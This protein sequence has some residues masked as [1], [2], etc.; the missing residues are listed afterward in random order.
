MNDFEQYMQL[1]EI[2]PV[3]LSIEA[4]VCYGTVYH[5]KKGVPILSENAEKIK[6]AVLSMTGV[7]YVGSFVLM[8]ENDQPFSTVCV[9][10]LPRRDP[11]YLKQTLQDIKRTTEITTKAIA[12]KAQLPVADVFAVEIGGCASWEKVQKVVRAFNELSGKQ[13]SVDEI[14]FSVPLHNDV[15]SFPHLQKRAHGRSVFDMQGK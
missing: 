3:R 4:H 5:A 2:D 1:H 12:E 14:Q 15:P 10:Q 6:E 8:E 7:P 9:K 13:I 11:H